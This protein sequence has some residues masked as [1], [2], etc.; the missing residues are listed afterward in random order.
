MGVLLAQCMSLLGREQDRLCHVLVK[1]P[2][3]DPRL[4]PLFLF[5]EQ[6]VV[7]R[8]PD[9]KRY[10]SKRARIELVDISF[11]RLRGLYQKEFKRA[12][13]SYMTL[14]RRL[15]G[16]APPPVNFPEVIINMKTGRVE[17]AGYSLRLSGA[18]FAL[19]SILMRGKR[20]GRNIR[21][22]FDLVDD[23][24]RLKAKRPTGASRAWHNDFKESSIGAEQDD[25]RK[26]ASRIRAKLRSLFPGQAFVEVLLPSLR[27]HVR[28]TYP[29]EKIRLLD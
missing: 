26:V 20:E 17:I 27:T 16:Q 29:P 13:A 19:F 25:L 10:P 1:P 21:D 6:S 24:A 23:F 2:Y 18:E 9:G 12:P 4:K 15:Q 7:H 22:W 28:D 3:D 5:P 14:V 11:V 8:T